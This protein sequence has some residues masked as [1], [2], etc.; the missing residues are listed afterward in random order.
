MNFRLRK[1]KVLSSII[2]PV[3]LWVILAFVDVSKI[4]SKIII[5][6][7]SLHNF[8]SLFSSGNILLFV[9]EVV[10]VYI[11]FSIFQRRY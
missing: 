4:S 6:F 10:V 11:I 9:I 7:I 5:N 1:T 8:D 3:I 2:I